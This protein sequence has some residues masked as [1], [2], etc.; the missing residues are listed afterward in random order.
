MAKKLT[1][2]ALS[3]DTKKMLEQICKK[4]ET[5]E[6]LIKRLLGDDKSIKLNI[7]NLLYEPAKKKA[8]EEGIDFEEYLWRLIKKDLKR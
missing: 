3:I 8:F 4:T 2:I 1:T 6:D 7:D 5:Y